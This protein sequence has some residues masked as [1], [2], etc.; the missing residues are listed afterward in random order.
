MT[1]QGSPSDATSFQDLEVRV[2]YENFVVIVAGIAFLAVAA[3]FLSNFK[4]FAPK[5]EK[6][7][8]GVAVGS[9]KAL[10]A[11]WTYQPAPAAGAAL[12]Q[13]AGS[14]QIGPIAGVSPTPAGASQDAP[15]DAP[16]QPP[17]R[18]ASEGRSAAAAGGQRH[19]AARAGNATLQGNK[20]P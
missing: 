14:G 8:V 4:V 1:H 6:P 5:A 7:I 15:G 9:G 17:V 11:P 10:A 20:N 19:A 2:K 12:V 13:A 3:W 18:A 16:A